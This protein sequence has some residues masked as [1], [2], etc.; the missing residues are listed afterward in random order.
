[1]TN[2]SKPTIIRNAD[3]VQVEIS[4]MRGQFAIV[5]AADYDRL[6]VAG[7]VGTWCFNMNGGRTHGYVRTKYKGN[8][9]TVAR[10]ILNDPTRQTV[11]YNN[12]SRLDLR[13]SNLS[14]GNSGRKYGR[15]F[16]ANA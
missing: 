13:R 2:S 3:T 5:D 10:L 12:G 16:A 1:M 8:N 9:S 4:N 15:T 14:L 7:H 11:R 6:R